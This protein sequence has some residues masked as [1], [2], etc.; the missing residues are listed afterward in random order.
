MTRAELL[1]RMSGHE[2][3]YWIAFYQRERREQDE[4]QDR[5]KDK[6]EA[7]RMARSMAGLH[8]G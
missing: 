5:V 6:A 3:A 7:Q 4:A 2:F 1:L 8:A